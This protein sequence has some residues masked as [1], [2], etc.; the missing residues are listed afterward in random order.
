ML[1]GVREPVVEDRSSDG[2]VGNLMV[3][4]TVILFYTTVESA[5]HCH[6]KAYVVSWV[7]W[8]HPLS[9]EG[10]SKR[11]GM[12]YN[13][14]VQSCVKIFKLATTENNAG[15][16]GEDVIMKAYGNDVPTRLNLLDEPVLHMTLIKIEGHFS[17]DDL[18]QSPLCLC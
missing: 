16:D 13:L 9:E 10:F 3:E 5:S 18:S 14:K 2:A 8:S 6:L 15:R 7:P 11:G 4:I 1:K 17:A 12:R